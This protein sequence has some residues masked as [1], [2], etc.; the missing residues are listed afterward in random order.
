LERVE[1]VI[2][3]GGPAGIATALF[4][5]HAAPEL[6]RRIVVL[7]KER[8]PREKFCAGAIGARADKLLGSIGVVVD[9]PSVPIRGIAFR[10]MGQ[11]VPVRDGERL[12]GR[13]VRRIEFDHALAEQA[14]R[15]EIAVRDGMAVNGLAVVPGGIELATSGGPIRAR[16]VVGADGVTSIVRRAL[17]LPSGAYRAQALEVDTE[18]VEGD[19]DRE[20]LLFDV[21]DRN[22]RG[23]Y[24]DFPTLV[25]GR[26]LV[27]RGIYALRDP[28]TPMREIQEVLDAQLTARGLD[29]RRYRK[30]RYAERGFERHEAYARPHVLLV[31]E[32]AG[33]DPVTG[34]GIAQAI[35]YGAVAGR[36]LANKLRNRDLRFDDW[37]AEIRAT[38][39]GRDLY[40]RTLGLPL[41]YGPR[42]PAI[43][44]FLL[45]TPEFVRVGLQ[46]FAGNRWSRAALLRAAKNA[47]L[48][49]ARSLAA[50]GLT[51]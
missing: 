10:A 32:A 22:L 26:P 2:V 49:T 5:S 27:C 23:Y 6:T 42:R 28:A 16:A 36:Y 38:M 4:L 33:I 20:L 24:W 48:H 1:I 25:E 37:R 35:Q 3:G 14:M 15:R 30:K 11:T 41:F 12:V 21:S 13:V 31:G 50:D 17:G 44:R 47:L 34:E 45:H 51:L 43:E 19:V 39:V 8:Y 29:L 7:E 9:V 40:V 18:P 46:H